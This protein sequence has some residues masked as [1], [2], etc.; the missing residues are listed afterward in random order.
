MKYLLTCIVSLVVA[1]SGYSAQVFV[2]WIK[3][4][5]SSDSADDLYMVV[6]RGR[7]TPPFNSNVGIVAPANFWV[8]FDDGELWPVPK[9][10]AGFSSDSVYVVLLMERDSGND[11]NNEDD[12][13]TWKSI[14]GAVWRAQRLSQTVAFLPDNEAQRNAAA[15]KVIESFGWALNTTSH[16]PEDPD[17][18]MGEPRRLVI[19]P[20]QGPPPMSFKESPPDGV[21][22][23]KFKIH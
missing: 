9:F 7:M 10:I 11:I 21:Y 2:D 14:T 18:K 23:V 3:C 5:K 17:D 20:G 12:I 8:D 22:K 16:F 4:I 13:K 1:A 6:F 15:N 19:S